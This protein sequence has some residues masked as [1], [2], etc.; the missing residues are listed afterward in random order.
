MA[1]KQ[2]P[3]GYWTEERITAIA[4]NYEYKSDFRIN[5]PMA[6]NRARYL[7]ILKKVTRG[8]KDKLK[9]H[10]RGYW[11]KCR[12]IKA[13]SKCKTLNE[14]RLKCK[15]AYGAS[16]TNGWF[17]EITKTLPRHTGFSKEDCRLDALNYNMRKDWETKSHATFWCAK[18]N[19]WLDELTAHMKRKNYYNKQIC[20]D[21]AKKCKT[22]K[23]FQSKYPSI[24]EHAQT[25]HY[26]DEICAHMERL[27]NWR[28]RKLYVFEFIDK[29]AYVGLS[30]NTTRR[31]WEHLHKEKSAVYKHLHGACDRYVFKVVSDW[32][33]KE[34]AANQE[35]NLIN[36]YKSKGWTM[37]N[38]RRGGALGSAKDLVYSKEQCHKEALK[39][40]YRKEFL[41][42]NRRL[43]EYAYK[44]KW[45]DDICKHMK[46]HPN[47]R[48]YWTEERLWN[49]VKECKTK[50][51]LSKRYNSA[52]QYIL[53]NHLIEKFYGTKGRNYKK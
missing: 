39:Y 24:Y 52:Y 2:H 47:W 4:Q 45:L 40:R 19:G 34:D 23:E 35:D 33:S 1:S 42:G 29:Y 48:L 30:Y 36:E 41:I 9:R 26:L 37:L 20:Q 27:G 50:S 3:D 32:L 22:R 15:G 31:K 10:P 11:T 25:H 53:R 7:G 8:M 18:Q 38:T 49:A 12:C 44:H 28:L 46:P 6:Y 21:T 16:K 13:V 43:Y 14:F 17:E 51:E 5:E